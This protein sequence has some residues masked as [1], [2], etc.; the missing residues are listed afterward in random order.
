MAER[1]QLP[2]LNQKLA[3]PAGS[4]P[5]VDGEEERPP[6]HWSAIGAVL[7]F[8]LWLPLA[9]VG[10]WLSSRLL[11]A[12]VPGGSAQ[13]IE[14]YLAGATASARLGVKA[15]TAG[16]PLLCFAAA[17]LAG[18]AMVGRFG[19]KAGTKEAAVGGLVAASTAW[20]LTAAAV[21]FGASWVLWPPVALLAVGFAFAGGRLGERLRPR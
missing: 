10:Q 15:A 2:I 5:G 16:P 8:A 14:G 12:L 20:A 13:Q 17:C 18:G 7:V 9:M 1:R 3:P 6:W 21:G 4:I 11:L 19:G